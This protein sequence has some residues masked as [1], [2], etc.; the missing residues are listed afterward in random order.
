MLPPIGITECFAINPYDGIQGT[1]ISASGTLCYFYSNFKTKV[2]LILNITILWLFKICES[3]VKRKTI[4]FLKP[5][6]SS[7]SHGYE[8]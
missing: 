1:A 8:Y 5:K 6:E 7:Q 4:F 3:E 2:P